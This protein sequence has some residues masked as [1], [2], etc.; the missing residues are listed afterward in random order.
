MQR[1]YIALI[2]LLLAVL[3]AAL[4]PGCQPLLADGSSSEGGEELQATTATPRSVV[5]LPTVMH[6]NA[7]SPIPGA[8]YQ[9]ISVT[10][11]PSDRPA[12][13]HGDLNLA[14]RGYTPT[15]GLLGLV[16]YNGGGDPGAPQL[17]GLFADRRT[18]V[19]QR[20]FRVNDWNWACNCRG[21]PL[22]SPEAT[23]ANLATTPGEIISLPVSGYQIGSGYQALVLYASAE[24]LTLKYTREDNVVRGYTLHL[25]GLCVEPALLALYQE[26]DAAGR[27]SLPALRGGQALG[28]ARGDVIGVAIRDTGRFLDPRSRK[29]WW[30]GR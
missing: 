24:R 20:V 27:R 21:D 8:A 11:P 26:R 9:A 25:E 14:L 28:R 2:M 13:A 10:P 4:L 12:E 19:F 1:S 15:A 16:T 17:P 18:A 22:A 30:Q 6:T 23:L 7:C 5:F 29:D 3:A